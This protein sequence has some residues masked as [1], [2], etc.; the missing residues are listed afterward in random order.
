MTREDFIADMSRIGRVERRV[1]PDGQV[2]AVLEAQTVP[3]VGRSSKVAFLLPEQVAG[4]PPAYVEGD[5]R[6]R[7]GGVPNNWSTT[8]MGTEVY[9]TWSFNCPWNPSTD[10][11]DVLVYAVLAQWNR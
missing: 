8:V 7:T 10:G 3:G 4:R 2:L 6:T 5:M 11:A 1:Q 9:G